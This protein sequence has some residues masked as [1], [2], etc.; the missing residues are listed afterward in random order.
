MTFELDH[1]FIC[2]TE[3]APEAELLIDFGL[4][5]GEPNTH[6]GQGTSNRRF[7]FHNAMLELLWISNPDE[8]KSDMTRPTR[9]WDRWESRGQKASPFGLC[10]RPIQRGIRNSTFK[11]WEYK[12]AYL[13]EHLSIFIGENSAKLNE[14]MIFCSPFGERPDAGGNDQPLEHL[15]GFREVSSLC[16]K[17]PAFD[18]MSD[19]LKSLRE[20]KELT[21]ETADEHVMEVG[22]DGEE[23]GKSI[24]FQPQLPLVFRW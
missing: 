12:P 21:F 3:G 11:G 16:V 15:S 20:I 18:S 13:P 6:P 5:E 14:P 23:T 8:A 22:F 1:I 24:S 17:S 7:F 19:T 4:T 10:L 9:L 2:V